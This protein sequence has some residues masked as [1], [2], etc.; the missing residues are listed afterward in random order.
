MKATRSVAMSG[1]LSNSW[2]A[3]ELDETGD[4]AAEQIG[5]IADAAYLMAIQC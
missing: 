1:Y 4:S 3:K 5:L 2:Q